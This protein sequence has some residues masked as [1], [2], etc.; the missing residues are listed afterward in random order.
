MTNS[1]R[2]DPNSSRLG[3]DELIGIVIAFA[4]IG[5][6]LA[7]TLSNKN[8]GFNLNQL[9]NPSTAESTTSAVRPQETSTPT[10][11]P[12]ATATPAPAATATPTPA[13]IAP[14]PSPSVVT[15]S[16]AVPA[17]S[18]Q[19]ARPAPV[20]VAAAPPTE[21]SP[22][23]TT[24]PAKP[25]PV[26]KFSDVPQD[27]WARPY[28]EALAT[29]GILKGYQNGTFKPG[30]SITREEFAALLQKAFETKPRAKA[31]N[32]KDVK[33]NSWALPAIQE[34]VKSGFL[35]GYP[36][37]L[38]RP[39]QPISKVQV[40]VALA[41]GLGLTPPRVSQELL[42]TYQDASQ[43][44]NYAKAPVSAAT[45]A[46]LVVNY[47]NPKVLNPK[48]NASRAEVAAMVYQ[49]M[50]RAGKVEA[51]SSKYLIKP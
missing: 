27:L 37:N 26:V 35:Q 48:Q 8:K 12:A 10:P 5:T 3:F 4:T 49:A 34:S 28:I 1:P 14:S 32:F 2:P 18:P 44:P 9:V 22:T 39:N 38:F 13:A 29:Q 50:V 17:P 40:L 41:N 25:A 46:G 15:A 36:N 31:A 21:A 45:Q 7:V 23:P 30:G 20:V 47:P 43:I 16:P 42:K 51:I 24:T 11:T 19:V 33:A 6:I